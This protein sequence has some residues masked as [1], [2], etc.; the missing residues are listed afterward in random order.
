MKAPTRVLLLFALL[1]ASV[2]S[3]SLEPDETNFGGGVDPDIDDPFSGMIF[4]YTSL[5]NSGFRQM[6]FEEAREWIEEAR[7]TPKGEWYDA[8]HHMYGGRGFEYQPNP[9]GER[10]HG[11]WWRYVPECGGPG[12]TYTWSA[13]EQTWIVR[14]PKYMYAMYCSSLNDEYM[15][16]KK[17][18]AEASIVEPGVVRVHVDKIPKWSSKIHN[19]NID[20]RWEDMFMRPWKNRHTAVSQPEDV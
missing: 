13:V 16:R 18:V 5:V 15:L 9:P 1:V 2:W 7:H 19:L 3:V 14:Y 12:S 6:T 4:D 11:E 20:T 17:A 8:E 10:V